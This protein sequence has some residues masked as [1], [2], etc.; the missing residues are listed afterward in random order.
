L[1]IYQ[2]YLAICVAATLHA[3]QAFA[4]ESQAS[5]ESATQA[6]SIEPKSDLGAM[7]EEVTVEP[8]QDSQQNTQQDSQFESNTIDPV[9][10]ISN[11]YSDMDMRVRLAVKADDK[12]CSADTCIENKAFDAKVQLIG[13]SLAKSAYAIYPEL[14]KTTPKFEFIVVDKKVLGS[15][16]NASGTIVL[17]RS[18]QHLD[19]DD[20]A[21]AFIIGREMGH[22]IARHHKSNAKTKIFFTVLTAVLFP[23]ASL[24]TASSAAAQATTATTLMTSAASTMTSFVGSEVALSRIKPSQLS[25]ADDISIALL[26]Y[27]GVTKADTAQSLEFIAEN[28][29]SVGWEK[30]LNLSIQNVRKLAGEPI[31]VVAELEP[32]PDAYVTAEADFVEPEVRVEEPVKMQ[33]NKLQP[34]TDSQAVESARKQL[35]PEQKPILQKL[36]E[37]KPTE[38]KSVQPKT[39]ERPKI[40]LITNQTLAESRKTKNTIPV[41]GK[42]EIKS[43]PKK[44]AS[45]VKKTKKDLTKKV[46]TKNVKP[47]KSDK[48]VVKTATIKSNKATTKEVKKSSKVSTAKVVKK[49]NSDKK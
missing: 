21:M 3:P 19:L 46:A 33:V 13:E 16:S 17:F 28:E 39:V 27:G 37:Q 24:I 34:L 9:E 2:S 41:K 8:Y 38:Q 1:K 6:E 7:P 25:E 32:L 10:D 4:E 40:I 5:V 15:A 20:D 48:H 36:V 11:F 44:D 49:T 12:P 45:N 35:K 18:I 29:N 43:N 30:D 26:E 31:E 22:V 47:K 23:A 42:L 14:K